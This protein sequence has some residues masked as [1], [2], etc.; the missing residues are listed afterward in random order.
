MLYALPKSNSPVGRQVE[1][2]ASNSLEKQRP[3]PEF[4][5]KRTVTG[6]IVRC[7]LR[8]YYPP[9]GDDRAGAR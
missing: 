5:L 2:I 6:V 9:A 3:S 1:K 7:I 8:D 4:D